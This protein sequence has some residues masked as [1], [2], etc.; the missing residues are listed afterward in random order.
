MIVLYAIM[1]FFLIFADDINLLDQPQQKWLG[2]IL[3]AYAA[4]RTYRNYKLSKNDRSNENAS[5]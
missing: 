2:G 4:Y 3:V 5:E 1:G